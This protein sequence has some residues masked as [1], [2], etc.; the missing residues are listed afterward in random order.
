MTPTP[1]PRGRHRLSRDEVAAI[2][3]S[4]IL[5]GMTEVMTER[6]YADTVVADIIKRAGVSRETFYQ[7]FSS[8]QECFIAAL[9]AATDHLAATL[10]QTAAGAGTPAE[11]LDRMIG[12]YLEVLA[13]D[14]PN[15]R[16]FLIETYAAGPE[17]M[18]RRLASQQRYVDGLA[19]IA[20]AGT[21][22][23]RFACE[24]LVAT[25]V[26]QVTARFITD[27]VE[28]LGELREPMVALAQRLLPRK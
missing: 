15:T 22:E 11:R 21:Q 19:E 1:L 5:R 9:D 18:R 26:T 10:R 24:A 7:R 16:L 6:G 13:A 20:G 28:T 2:Q 23:Q 25:L 3:R 27:R 14:P 8:K 12:T 4:R 17:A